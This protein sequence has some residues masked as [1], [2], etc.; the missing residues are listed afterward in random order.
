MLLLGIIFGFL[1]SISFFL[2]DLFTDIAIIIMIKQVLTTTISL[3]FIFT[4]HLKAQVITWGPANP[5]V[6]SENINTCYEDGELTLEFTNAGPVLVDASIEIELDTGINY[7]PSSLTFSS[8]GSATVIE[9]DISNLNHP[10]FKI[11]AVAAAEEITISIQRA[12]NC[13]AM[14]LKIGGSTFIDAAKV[15]EVG[16]EV[17]YSNSAAAGTVN[18]DVIY[19]SLSITNVDTDLAVNNLGSSS[20]RTMNITNGSF[21]VIEGFYFADVFNAGDLTVSDFII[22][23]MGSNYAIPVGNITISGDSV[24]VQF[25]AAEIAEIDGSVGTVGDGDA[26]FEKDETFILEYTVRPNSCGVSNTIASELLAWFGCSYEERCQYAENAASLGLTNATPSI[27]LSNASKPSLDFCDTVTY[28]VTLTNNTAETTPAG[29][30]FAKDVTAF[31]GFRANASPISTLANVTQWGS[32][33]HNTKFFVNH[34]LNGVSVTLP[35]IPGLYGTVVPYLPPDY[36]DYDPDGPGGLTDVDLDGYFDDLPKDSV[37]VISYGTYIIPKD[38][39]CSVGRYDYIGWEH[40]SADIS[41]HN[42]CG[43]LMSPKRQEFNYTNHIRDYLNSTFIDSPTDLS[44][45]DTISVGIKPHLSTGIK[46]DG[47]SGASGAGV[48]WITQIVLPAGLSM[49]P[50]YDPLVY[51]VNND[52]VT[53][54][55]AYSYTWTNFPLVFECDDW[56]GSNPVSLDFTTIYL[57]TNGTDTCYQEE[58]HC[59]NVNM[60]PHCPSPCV[61]VTP[62]SFTTKRVSESW[63]DNTQTTLVDLDDPSIVTDFVYPFDTVEFNTTGV[64]SDTMSDQLYLRVTYS[65]ESGGNIFSFEEGTIEI[66]DIDGQYNGGT[67]NY[68]FPLSA[69]PTV[70]DLGGDNYEMIFDLSSY[71]NS[72]DPAYQYGQGAGGPPAYDPDTIK[73]SAR[74]VISSTM[75]VY[76]P[77][78]VNNLRSEFFIYD[79]A[80]NEVSCNSWGSSLSY[81]KPYSYAGDHSNSNYGCNSDIQNFYLTHQALTGDDHPNEYR[82]PYQ[83]DSAIVTIPLGWDLDDVYWLNGTVMNSSDYELKPDRTLIIRRPSTYKDYDKRNTFYPKFQVKVTPNCQAVAGNNN[84]F[85]YTVYLKDYA[86]LTDTSAHVPRTSSDN[87]GRISYTP[88]TMT[89]TPLNQTVSA[90]EDTVQWTVR[91]CNSTSDMDVDFNWLLLENNGNQIQVDSV[92]DITGGGSTLLADST[93]A[94]GGIYVQIGALDQGECTDLIIYSS[95]TSCDRDTLQIS[96]GW[97]CSSYP[98]TDDVVACGAQNEVY[99]LPQAAQVSTTI[100]PLTD[101]PSDPSDPGAGTWGSSSVDM[102]S[103]FPAEV[104][105]INAQPAYLYDVTLKIKIPSSGSG[106]VYVPG[107]ATIEVEGIDA[108]NTPRSIGATAESSLVTSSNNGD[109]FW[110]VTLEELDPTNYGNGEPFSGT[111]NSSNNEFILR[112]EMESTCDLVSGDNFNVTIEG[113]DPCGSPAEGSGEQ[114]NGFPINLNGV[115][116]PYFSFITVDITPD[117]EVKGCDDGKTIELELLLTSG[118]TGSTDSL[119]IILPEGIGY[120]GNFVCNTPGKCPIYIGSSIINGEEILSFKYPAG[121]TGSID[122]TFDITTDDRGGCGTNEVIKFQSKTTLT[123]L[124]C[125][126]GSCASTEVFT[127]NE[128]INISI[129]KPILDVAFT[130]L[131]ANTVTTPTTFSYDID[132][133]NTGIDT[134][135]DVIVEFYCLNA[136]GDDII[137]SALAK[138]TVTSIL[139]NGSTATLSGEFGASCNTADGIAVLIVPEYDNCY[140]TALND[141]GEK[142]AGLSEIPHDK[143]S[144]VALPIELEAFSATVDDCEIT[145]KWTTQTEIDNDYIDIERSF[146]GTSFIPF[147]RFEGDI[148]SYESK[149]YEVKDMHERFVEKV[150]YRLKQADQNGSINYSNV[151]LVEPKGCG[152]EEDQRLNVYPNPVRKGNEVSV[153]FK[154]YITNNKVTVSIAGI[155]GTVLQSF[156]LS[157]LQ[158]GKNSFTIDLSNLPGGTYTILVEQLN[159][160]ILREKLA[161][162]KL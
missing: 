56:D 61:G 47:A 150:Y 60:V 71:R 25:T 114:V 132:I 82:P 140:C 11:G 63:T 52:T 14:A 149:F 125:G 67:T 57:C 81:E 90:Y 19:G 28:S 10:V 135:N 111:L 160:K 134:E 130:Y 3:F 121:V 119:D 123:G 127:G 4:L 83:V 109:L 103:A 122:F 51:N 8:T 18:Y 110:I 141:M 138:D 26:I 29:G 72:V 80:S 16:T 64:F 68:S 36:F 145:I 7:V 87:A 35:T 20:T 9:H 108:V 128:E 46:C 162:M 76:S 146:D 70:N 30:G 89:L 38:P 161:V 15:Y 84:K 139:M 1:P 53:T 155:N 102:C 148:D 116:A 34:K 31:L 24:I 2:S 158:Q 107:S 79:A 105:V 124:T 156:P 40:I 97:S 65:P 92:V 59:Y 32:G 126:G 99:I 98:T 152:N 22:N 42:Q 5:A 147:K 112:W 13:E 85:D 142:S 117:N 86:Y 41:W 131:L 88:P 12:A 39:A 69:A 94:S 66:V 106:L 54:S 143:I 27:V 45:G 133:T 43:T 50:G 159:G 100:T 95:F 118:S 113:N 77:W 21:G 137:G 78:K 48:E 74:V 136:A 17:S 93:T 115:A 153:I 37:L 33:R 151:I 55:A 129:E 58:V 157:N 104:M 23:P 120:D 96:H 62:L 144:N 6:T 44:D 73:L 101:T 91:V 75:T 49:K 154:N